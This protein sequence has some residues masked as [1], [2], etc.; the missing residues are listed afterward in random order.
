[1]ATWIWIWLAVLAVMIGAV[2]LLLVGNARRRRRMTNLDVL[3][4]DQPSHW[5]L[6]D[7]FE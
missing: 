1:M 4:E 7:G 2:A 6:F 5:D 3:A